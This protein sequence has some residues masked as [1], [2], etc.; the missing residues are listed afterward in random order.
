VKIHVVNHHFW[1]DGS[2]SAVLEE[3]LADSLRDLGHDTVLVAGSGS[4]HLTERAA[5]ASPVI[6]LASREAGQRHTQWAILRDYGRFWKAIRA[7]LRQQVRPGEAILATTSPF[8]NV[9]LVAQARRQGGVVTIMHLQ[10]Y[11]PANLRSLSLAHRLVAPL[12]KVVMDRWLARWDLVLP[13]AGNLA[14]HRANARVIRHWP[15]IEAVPGRQVD[16]SAKRALYAGNLGIAHDIGALVRQLDR[17]HADGWAIDFYGD[18]PGVAQLPGYVAVHRFVSGQEYLD[19]LYSHPVH[20]VAGVRRDG[21]GSFPSKTFNSLLVGAEVI[22]CGFTAEMR[23]ELE[24]V[25]AEPDLPGYRQQAA[26]VID[27]FLA[28]RQPR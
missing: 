5:P 10:D 23:Q 25:K 24:L 6:T 26:R 27:D 20:L 4:F 19:A 13:C 2:P 15:T 7:Y 11:L 14:Y 3:A 17:L 28:G 8:L 18:G 1:P 12:V 16:R 9:F 22:P 21:T